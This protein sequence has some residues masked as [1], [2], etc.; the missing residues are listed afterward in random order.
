MNYIYKAGLDV[1]STTAKLVIVDVEN[2]IKYSNYVRHHADVR[3]TLQR[4]FGEVKQ[5]LGSCFLRLSVTGS[6]GMGI[7]ERFHLPFVQEVVAETN[8]IKQLYPDCKTLV[9]IG[10]E[11]AKM[12]FFTEDLL[13]NMRMNGNCAGGTGAFIDQMAVLLACEV[14]DLNDLALKSQYIH[15]IA[16]RCGVFSKTDIQNLIARN[17]SKED[18][19]ASIFH[20]VAVQTV[21]S[22]SHGADIV[23]K[24]LFCGGPFAFIPALKDAFVNYL[25]LTEDQYVVPENATIITA[26]GTAL[27]ENKDSQE[28]ALDS[29]IDEL[30][31]EDNFKNVIKTNRLAPLFESEE[32]LK[33]WKK[34]K[35]NSAI[36]RVPIA[37]SV[38]DCYLGIDSGSTTTKI[39][40]IDQNED[41][42]FSYYAN[43][44]GNPINTMLRGLQQFYDE[45]QQSG[46]NIRIHASTSTGY[47]EDLIKAAFGLNF[48]I[49]ETIAH[50]LAAKHTS[51]NVSFILDIGGQ[52]MKALFVQNGSLNRIEIN[53]ACSS[54]CGSFIEAFAK[55]L[56]YSISDFVKLACTAPSP[57]D[58]GT[59]CTVFMNSKVKQFLREGSSV[60]DIS[61]GL[62]YSVVKNCLYK[63]LK[64][65]NL[66]EL[67]DHLVVQGGTMRNISVVRAFEKMTNKSVSFSSI[68]ELMGAFGCALYAKS[69]AV[70]EGVDLKELLNM[71]KSQTSQ[72]QC[73]GCENQCQITT[74]KFENGNKYYS[75]NK[76]ERI[77]SNKGE[78]FEIGRNVYLEKRKKLFNRPCKHYENALTIGIPRALGMYEN[79]PFWHALFQTAGLNVVLT[80]TSTYTK[81]EKGLN[82]VMADNICFPAKLI[83]SHIY[84]LI[85][86]KVDRI[87]YPYIVYEH[88]EDKDAANSYNCPIVAGYSD[89][90][91]SAIDP[92][93]KFGIP[94]DAPS[95]T[96]KDE[97]LLR[98]NC[99]NYL[100]KLGVDEGKI[101]SAIDAALV[102]QI[103]YVKEMKSLTHDIFTENQEKGKL[104]ILLAG[105]PYHTDALV[106]HKLSEMIAGLGA[107]VITEDIVRFDEDINIREAHAVTQWTYINRIL[108]AAQWVAAQDKNVHFVQMTSF[109]C[110]PDS[111]LLDE[112]SSILK[113][114]GKS[115]TILKIDDVNNI[116]SLK[117]RVRSLIESLKFDSEIKLQPQPFFTTKPFEIEDKKRTILAP[118]FSEYLSPMIEALFSLAGYEI[119][120]LP[121][122]NQS[123]IDAG[124][125]YVNN[126]VCYPCTLVVGDL[127]KALKSGKYDLAKT[128][129]ALTQT[130]G[131]CRATNYVAL[132]KKAMT[133]AGFKDVPVVAV[134]TNG[135]FFNE[136]PGFEVNW[137]KIAP[138]AIRVMYFAD[139]ISKFYAST[140]VR[141]KSKG[142][143]IHLRDKYLNEGVALVRSGNSKKLIKLI[144][145]A[146]K[147]FNDNAV[148]TLKPIPKVGV[149]GEIYL[150]FNAFSH[151]YVT[152]WLQEQGI[153]V[154]PPI[155]TPFFLQ[156]F[157]NRKVKISERLDTSK[158]PSFLMNLVY[159]SVKRYMNKVNKVASEFRFFIPFNDIFEEAEN[160]QNVVSL[161]AQFGEGWLI[162]AEFVSFAKMNVHNVVSLQPF[163]CIANHVI[164][165]GIE[166]RIKDMY[167][168][169][170]LLFLDFDSGVSDVNVLNR[171][172]LLVNNL[173]EES[174]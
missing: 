26:L 98:K 11:D 68:P 65:K 29:I 158:V 25:H 139:S 163:G 7:A 116:G 165:K 174:K 170:N 5:Q 149:V 95:I 72:T 131:Q 169:M 43:N 30:N 3:G 27:W 126:E 81:Y 162:P 99:E 143:A 145:K 37:D 46:R 114:N 84:E 79:Y 15:P 63:V 106:Q 40:V 115:L 8:V 151:K 28:M 113:R 107:D 49:I 69:H 35:D 75:G 141:E 122:S 9:D 39:V 160:A 173:Q 129:V 14:K 172:H 6:A 150:K 94:I 137:F 44:E 88:K 4:L 161:S 103:E 47:G 120:T 70:G 153:E 56:N 92:K 125:E 154:I 101:V 23:P 67:G 140:V 54:G 118:F 100:R 38:G 61:A 62:A 128:A 164:S 171:L 132:L 80:E 97:K 134:A 45:T 104:T 13:P 59:R 142:V 96:F 110:G 108:K 105:R 117:L 156:S 85:E 20:A 124:L 10:G 102:A 1:G 19:A 64:I 82:T 166:K 168:Q 111:F 17:V 91:K 57:C 21:T 52:D 55:S 53:E 148:D 119:V 157:V 89:V 36:K 74:Y 83:H 147:E 135:T 152:A 32:E 2:K 71:A 41:L 42:V 90:L 130:G 50:Y 133:E 16:S 123:S 136:Q 48:G 60:A 146:A 109:G 112:V 127:I 86:K 18:I 155:I 31:N 51:P 76:C 66:S 87:F 73:K 12:V 93:H 159:K 77:F 24:I 78:T 138:V 144:A 22:L 121:M 33:D 58:L 167:P 34:Q